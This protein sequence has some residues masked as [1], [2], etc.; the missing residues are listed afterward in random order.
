MT[1]SKN[2]IVVSLVL[3]ISTMPALAQVTTKDKSDFPELKGPYLS[4]KP[5]GK[6]AELFAPGI[7]NTSDHDYHSDYLLSDKFFIFKRLKPGGRSSI[8]VTKI[9]N[10]KWTKPTLSPFM[11]KPWYHNYPYASEGQII[12]FAWR[13]S[14]GNVT[15]SN[16][17]NIWMVKKMVK[18]WSNP[19]KLKSP[20]NTLSYDTWASAARNR[21]IYFFSGREGGYGRSDIYRSQ[22]KNGEHIDV[23]NLGKIINTGYI[24]NDPF[25]APD[26]RY[27]IFCSNRPGG[28]G[29]LDCYI[30]FKKKDGS[31]GEPVN[32][33]TAVNS[34]SNEERPYVTPDGKYFFFT[35]TRN[36]LLDIY[37]VSADIIEDLHSKNRR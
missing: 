31:W 6:K 2:I 34:S 35:S 10:G 18:G 21:T 7:I 33:G 24:D 8:L 25:I 29:K 26:E 28:K 5:P 4:Q 20:V 22:L 17:L 14:L 27:L 15:A 36:G 3:F 12:Y 37:W 1:T 9:K 13:G 16:D 19:E 32:M 11:G 30:S 23:E